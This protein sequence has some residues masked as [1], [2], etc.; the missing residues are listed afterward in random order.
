MSRTRCRHLS[1]HRST[2]FGRPLDS[3]AARKAPHRRILHRRRTGQRVAGATRGPE[4]Q[5]SDPSLRR[6]QGGIRRKAADPR[7]DPAPR[8]S[9]PRPV[10]PRRLPVARRGG[11][12]RLDRRCVGFSRRKI[13]PARRRIAWRPE[14]WAARKPLGIERPGR[15]N[16][17]GGPA[18]PP[19]HPEGVRR[20]VREPNLGRTDSK[21]RLDLRSFVLLPSACLRPHG[22]ARLHG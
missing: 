3:S 17:S 11:S 2:G 18:S 12:T 7:P 13:R 6:A 20:S 8:P 16:L 4:A 9:R 1:K 19:V 21:I 22:P 15:S 10:R 5:T 14:T